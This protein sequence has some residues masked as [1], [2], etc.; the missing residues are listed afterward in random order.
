MKSFVGSTSLGRSFTGTG[1]S[2]KDAFVR[3]DRWVGC[4]P[5]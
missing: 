2:F 5:G 4:G 3:Q 1:R